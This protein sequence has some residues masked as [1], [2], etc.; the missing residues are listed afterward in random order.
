MPHSPIACIRRH[1]RAHPST[2]CTLRIARAFDQNRAIGKA[3]VSPAAVVRTSDATVVGT[4]HTLGFRAGAE[5]RDELAATI[6]LRLSLAANMR[7]VLAEFGDA[8]DDAVTSVLEADRQTIVEVRWRR[9]NGEDQYHCP[10]TA[11]HS[12]AQDWTLNTVGALRG[13]SV[14]RNSR[15]AHVVE[16]IGGTPLA[17][18]LV[19]LRDGDPM[20]T[21]RFRQPRIGDGRSARY[22]GA[23]RRRST[24]RHESARGYVLNLV[25]A[26]QLV[27]TVCE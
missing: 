6:E 3:A 17:D 10:A 27:L 11:S 1:A 26:A 8:W 24:R 19:D 16:T 20:L 12:P 15:A 7:P 5:L 21:C 22:F 9:S 25:G 2:S 18:P 14:R 23:I 13:R 4:V